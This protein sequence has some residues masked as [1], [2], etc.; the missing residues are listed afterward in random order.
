LKMFKILA[1][2]F[3]ISLCGWS[4]VACAC[5]GCLRGYLCCD[6]TV[7][8]PTCYHPAQ[9]NCVNNQLCPA[10]FGACGVICFDPNMYSCN[11]DSVL[12]AAEPMS[13]SSLSN[14]QLGSL[15][16]TAP[17]T[18]QRQALLE[19][20][21][22]VFN[23]INATSGISKGTGGTT[24]S[25]A[26][27]NFPALIG[28]G[29][30][31]TI[32]YIAPCSINLPH[33]H[34]RA[35]EINFIVE[36]EFEAGFFQENMAKFVGNTI[37]K[38]MVTVFPMGAIH[39]EQNLQCDPAMFVAAFNNEDPGVLTVASGYFGLPAEIAAAGLNL[40]ITT[41]EQLAK[42]LPANPALGLLE[43]RQRC[44]LDQEVGDL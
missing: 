7:N 32:G 22:Y 3:F 31:M 38:G 35:T 11:N 24:I 13:L 43:C 33:T 40:T 15:L 14:A 41:V 10:Q 16:K 44:G 17:S 34:P 23:F 36:G 29:I 6:D 4:C 20:S 26:A 1:S 39:F 2:L 25:A 21:Q 28:N 30:A 19:D 42:F 37:S 12:T 18:L 27:I 5:N 8:G 9:Y